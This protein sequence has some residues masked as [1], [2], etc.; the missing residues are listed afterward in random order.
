MAAAASPPV[1]SKADAPSRPD[2]Y[3][4]PPSL[5]I[6]GES[7]ALCK[8]AESCKLK[9]E[10]LSINPALLPTLEDLLIEIYATLRPKPDD[11]E[12]RHLM[13]GVFNKIAEEI[14]GK[15]KGFPVVEAF[16]SF[17]MDLFTPKSDL[18]LSINFNA[19]FDS[20]F[21]RKDKISVIRKL[22]KVLHAHQRNGRCH[23]VLPVVTAKVPVLKVIDKGTGV[24]CDI[25]VENKDGMSRSVIFKLISSIDERLQILC[26]LMK[27]WAKAHDVNCPRDRTMSSMTIISLVAFHLQTRRPPLL[28]AFSALLKDGS[29]FTSI[30]KNVSLFEGFG[31]RNKE[32]VAELFVSLMSK[33]LSVE[34]LWEQGLCASNF[35][36]SWIFKTW[37]RGIGNLSVEDFLDRSQNFARAV[38][39]MEMQ[40]ICECIRVAVL[41]LNNFFR[42]KIDAPK[43]KSLLFEPLHQDKLSRTYGPKRAIKRKIN[44]TYGPENNTKQQKKAKHVGPENNQKQQPKVK[45]TV[46]SGPSVSRSA[47]DLHRPTTLVPHIPQVLPIQPISQLA[48]VPQLLVDPRLAYGLPPQHHLHSDPL[49]SQGLLGQQQGHFINLNPGIQLQQQAQHVFVPLLAQQPAM[50]TFHPY[51]FQLA[52]QIQHNE[53]IMRQMM[54]YGTYP[55]YRR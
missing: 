44:S 7:K 41:N 33:L 8:R 40:R 13:I 45:H 31:S 34:G 6:S 15:R 4:R 3:P 39:K 50:N 14:F 37:E 10:A 54:P 5:A 47:T 19:D 36:G 25:S 42:G 26:Y 1:P 53:H 49:Y 28:P 51:D 52:Q 24:E 48:H 22:A 35:E 30:Q 17:T 43:L 29:D 16:G 38:G 23:G 27:F 18:D 9:S 2:H 11:Y 21:A 46:N 20:Q 32:S 12:Q 55:Y